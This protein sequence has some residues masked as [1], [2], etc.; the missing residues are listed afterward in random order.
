MQ[1]LVSVSQIV[2]DGTYELKICHPEE[3]FPLVE[4]LKIS[5]RHWP[6]RQ[7]AKFDQNILQLFKLSCSQSDRHTRKHTHTHTQLTNAHSLPNGG[8]LKATRMRGK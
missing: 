7:R 6:S 8:S 3:L 1:N 4:T 2:Y 5:F